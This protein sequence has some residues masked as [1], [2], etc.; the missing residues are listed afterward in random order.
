MEKRDGFGSKLGILAAAAGSAIGLGNIWKFPYITGVNG[1]GAFLIV[2]LIC[3]ALVG[4]TIM[5]CEFTIGRR[6]QMNPIGA[7]KKLS[8]GG[9]WWI[10]GLSGVLC[11]FSI[12]SFYAV[13]AGWVFAYV[14]RAIT[15]SLIKVGADQIGGLFGG[16]ISSTGEPIFWAFVVLVLTALIIVG[17]I[18]KGIEK[19][20]KILM[21][22][23]LVL[24]V[25][26]MIRSVTL[27]GASKGL[28]FLF[29]PDFS[30]L[31]P[32][33]V[34]EAL[35]H[36][37]FSLSLGMGTMITYGSYISK[38][39]NLPSMAL[40]VS[41]ADTVIALMAGIVIFPA[42][43]AFGLEP[44]SGPGLIFV[45]LPP[46]F[47]SMPLGGVFETLFFT[48]IG[49]AA[50]TST[51]SILEVVVA[52]VCENYNMARKKATIMI[53][54]ITF[55]FSVLCSLSLGT[56]SDFTIFGL[57]FFDLFDALSSKILLPGGG[58]LIAIFVGWVMKK[59]DV[60][61]EVTNGGEIE[62]GLFNAFMFVTKYL[63]PI[64]IAIVFAY[65]LGLLKL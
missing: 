36:A 6:A 57:G 50:L 28:E 53:A 27:P 60:L 54:A 55:F 22:I 17:G 45:T 35:G 44:G 2:Y 4:V 63:A 39:E 46:V 20:S 19:Y 51:I 3:I 13:V 56:M 32:T 24:L 12:L 5:L 37:F 65:S 15:G 30:K 48:L 40:Q 7:F 25:I 11:A 33:G 9:P 43:F 29:K 31:T 52:F 21:P 41:I 18:Q 61:D 47:Q 42:V 1:G 34:L 14:S 16:L 59:E 38:K 62:F 26:L 23:L 58:L 8:K 64:L 49:I 10:V